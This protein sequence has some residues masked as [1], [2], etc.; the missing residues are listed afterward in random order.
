MASGFGNG[1]TSGL[2]Y[3]RLS[4]LQ[5]ITSGVTPASDIQQLTSVVGGRA[6]VADESSEQ[7]LLTH[8]RH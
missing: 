6:D 3:E 7:P 2:G 8:N 1:S 5:K 4:G